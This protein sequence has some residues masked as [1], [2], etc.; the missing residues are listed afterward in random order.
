MNERLSS[1]QIVA[2]LGYAVGMAAGQILF[3]LAAR[4]M[5]PD[6]GLLDRAISLSTS[7]YFLAAL[8]LYLVLSAIWVWLLSFTALSQAYLF[9]ILSVVLVPLLGFVIFGEPVSMRLIVGMLII[10]AGLFVVAG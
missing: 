8:V 5:P 6:S 1:L 10:L 2:L 9:A 3:K 4:Q 7:A